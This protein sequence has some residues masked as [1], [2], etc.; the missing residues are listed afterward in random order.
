MERATT[1]DPNE[2]PDG[3]H[4][5]IPLAEKWAIRNPILRD[6]AIEEAPREEVI[7]FIQAVKDHRAIIDDWLN[8]LPK[9]IKDC[10][11]K[12]A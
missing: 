4:V 5:L 2:V 8:N 1:I 9:D 10:R 11:E 7:S 6:D 3:L 12:L